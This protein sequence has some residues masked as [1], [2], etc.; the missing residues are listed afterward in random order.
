MVD[1]GDL[2]PREAVFHDGSTGEQMHNWYVHSY[3]HAEHELFKER[4]G[5]DFILFARGAAPGTQVEAGQMSGDHASTYRGLEESIKGGLSLSSSGFSNWGSDVGGLVGKPDE[6]VYLRWIEFGTFSPLMRF[7]GTT[8]REPW[9]F[10]DA[11]VVTY[12]KYAWVRENLRP[13][14]YGEAQDAHATGVPMMRALPA[15]AE[16]EYMFGDDLLVAPVYRPGEQRTVTLPTGAWTELWTGA[17]VAAGERSVAAP[18]DEIPVYLRAGALVP[19]E[20]APDFVLGQ[21]MSVGRIPM[22]LVT[23][24][25]A[26]GASHRW[27]LPEGYETVEMVSKA[28]VH[29]FTVTV[30]G[31]HELEYVCVSGLD[32]EIAGVT[33][34]GET[35]PEL[36]SKAAEAF[37]PGWRRLGPHRIVV[38]MPEAMDHVVQISMK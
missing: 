28:D 26:D 3:N 1:F 7:H 10:S 15:V 17:P 5:D 36:E 29:G 18:L 12:K 31:W 25:E 8:P 32:G 38:R 24:P 4:R 30:K 35:L 16:D 13:Y 2:V 6:E 33:A 20:V 22:L 11:A 37:G 34:G 21:S 19:L 14:L 23:P 9:F 27:R